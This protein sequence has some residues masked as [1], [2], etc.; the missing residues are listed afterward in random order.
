MLPPPMMVASSRATGAPGLPVYGPPASADGGQ[1]EPSLVTK[2]S[3]LTENGRTG[4]PTGIG[5]F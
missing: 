4:L 1:S 5:S 3:W 2:A